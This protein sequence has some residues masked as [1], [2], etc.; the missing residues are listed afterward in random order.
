VGGVNGD[1]LAIFGTANDALSPANLSVFYHINSSSAATL[2]NG[3]W[4]SSN[5]TTH[6]D[7]SWTRAGGTT[8]G[9]NVVMS[10]VSTEGSY[11]LHVIAYDAVGNY[12]AFSPP[13]QF[14][15]DLN[16]PYMGNWS[17]SYRNGVRLPN[18][19]TDTAPGVYVDKTQYG[20]DNKKWAVKVNR[21]GMTDGNYSY[22]INIKDITG[23]TNALD[24]LPGIPANAHK[25]FTVKVDTTPPKLGPGI[26]ASGDP[27][28]IGLNNAVMSG[29]SWIGGSDAL[30]GTAWDNDGVTYLHY[31]IQAADDPAPANLV[32]ARSNNAFMTDNDWTSLTIQSSADVS[33]NWSSVG[34]VKIFV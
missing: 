25:N 33:A 2:P 7:T 3:A 30:K 34:L 22:V 31:K 18:A 12:S 23:K 19:A 14:Y 4:D 16:P 13:H 15:V 26:A 27:A 8:W 11:Y 17:T 29:V 6:P 32:A 10:S 9:Q 24:N 21:S 28:T 20:S 1:T 5:P